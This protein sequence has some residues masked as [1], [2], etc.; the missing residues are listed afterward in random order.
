MPKKKRAC[1]QCYNITEENQCPLC[2][3]ETASEWQGYLVIIDHEHSELARKMRIQA[4]GKYAL[5]VRK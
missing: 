1:R 5:K 4:N 2:G 3:A